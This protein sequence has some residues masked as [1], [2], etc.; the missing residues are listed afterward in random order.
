[1]SI[2]SK[3]ALALCICA[4]P[5]QAHEF[6][7]DANDYTVPE[8]GT[9]VATFRNGENL[10]G[11]ALSYIPGRSNRF[12][13]VVDGEVRPI[14]SRM[15]DN[16]AISV[17]GLDAGL[18]TLLHETREQT[19]TYREW[20]KW[21]SFTDHKDFAWSQQA[22]LD[23]GLPQEGFR[24]AYLRFAKALVAVGEGAG[25][26]VPR[27]LRTE[28]VLGANPYTDDLSD[29]LPVQVLLEGAPKA[30]AQIEMF[31]RDPSGAVEVTLHRADEEGRATLPV[32]PGHDYLLDS[33][34]LVPQEPEG[35][36]DPV[37]L[38]LWAALTF[39]VPQG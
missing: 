2:L 10:V 12:E 17:E 9:V 18:V 5:L 20:E 15:G 16:P 39:A 1:M 35:E 26:D 6:W 8:G 38:S 36:R 24:E 32:A 30:N 14:P 22:H 33:V 7:I 21:V 37:W 25:Q 31:E 29:G 19:V 27:G 28:I 4:S 23:R 34:T 11:S 3:T 13:M